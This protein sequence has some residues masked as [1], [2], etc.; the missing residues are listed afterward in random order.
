MP[1]PDREPLQGTPLLWRTPEHW[2]E[3]VDTRLLLDELVVVFARFL[4]LSSGG[5]ETLALWTLQTYA[6]NVAEVSPILA[7]TSPEKRCGKSR[8]LQI[9]GSLVPR[10]LL[11]ANLTVAGV[12]RTIEEFHPTLLV[13][14]AD[15]FLAEREELRG[16]LNSGHCRA[17]AY[18]LRTDGDRHRPRTFSTFGPKAIAM[19]GQL[20]DT[21]RDR[22]I[23][24]RMQRRLPSEPIER[25]RT[26]RISAEFEPLRRRAGRWVQ[27]NA[28][29]LRE[30]DPLIPVELGD[31]ETDNWRLVFAIAEL[32]GGR[33]PES[34]RRVAGSHSV[35]HHDFE[36]SVRIQLL[37]DIR[38]ILE[39]EP[40]FGSWV[41]S[42]DIA[43]GL[44][45]FQEGQWAEWNRGK[46]ISKAQ[47][48]KLLSR[49]GLGP[50]MQR[51]ADKT[52]SDYSADA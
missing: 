5:S 16:I 47:I 42:E 22:A 31:R 27:D 40:E 8:V 6:H 1:K 13:D 34:A 44:A 39:P 4:S 15:T 46:P 10:P 3:F 20:P 35:A 52:L 43:N 25:L 41:A 2:P 51:I 17:H 18:V 21:L 12:F 48:A 7:I 23:E 9:L 14:E 19:I 36:A 26:D 32:A 45:A 28:A 30:A 24:L 33:W 49:V 11:T 29:G 37:S 50:R 38:S